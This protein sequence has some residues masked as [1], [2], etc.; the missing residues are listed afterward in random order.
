VTDPRAETEAVTRHP[1]VASLG[2][3]ADEQDRVDAFAHDLAAW[4]VGLPHEELRPLARVVT[5]VAGP[6]LR[7]TR[8]LCAGLPLLAVE[9]AARAVEALW[10]HL[11]DAWQD[12]DV[13]DLAPP[14]GQPGSDSAD[15]GGADASAAAE[16]G[17][18]AQ[19]GQPAGGE[20]S[21]L[22]DEDDPDLDALA[23][24]LARRAATPAASAAGELAAA[25][26]P[27]GAAAWKGAREGEEVARAM[28]Q[29]LPGVGWGV[30]TGHLQRALLKNLEPYA[31]LVTAL[32]ELRA[33]AERLG[34]LEA[35]SR[36]ESR[37]EGGSE[38]V[39][40]VR[41]G[42]DVSRAL[43][44]ELALLGDPVTEDLFYQ[45]YAEGRLLSLELQGSGLDGV[46]TPARRGPV[47]C[48]VDTSGSMRGP[49]GVLA[50]AVV[51]AVA[52]RLL[53]EGRA[54]HVLL[55]GGAG[56]QKELRLRR[57]HGGLEDLLELV[58]W[59]FGGGTDFDTPLLRACELL[60]ERGLEGAD[61]L[62]VTDGLARASASVEEAVADARRRTGLR[63]ISL[64]LGGSDADVRPFSDEVWRLEVDAGVMGLT[65]ALLGARDGPPARRGG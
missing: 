48:A 39:T 57:G 63:C 37:K 20:L 23:E 30:A 15:G 25:A 40:G 64:V 31:K 8:A 58:A 62:V 34:R 28:A 29:L 2:R 9:A 1:R 5:L 38:E 41:L 61:V 11:A 3:D 55:F 44:A 4:L 49:P 18:D 60:T 42:G 21:A 33:L 10:P 43:P 27:A 52:R 24:H 19:D 47:I 22:A 7:D 12:A 51:L 35:S 32:P 56:E 59:E 65:R 16:P 53:P 6:V 26:S 54:V 46:S 17:G 14:S 45:R 13:E 36:R 50:K